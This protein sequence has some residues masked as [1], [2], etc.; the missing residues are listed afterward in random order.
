MDSVLAHGC[1]QLVGSLHYS[2]M[3][4]V[5]GTRPEGGGTSGKE[6]N[7]RGEEVVIAA[8]RVIVASRCEWVRI[9]LQ[10]GMKEDRE[11]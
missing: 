2:D 4:F 3:K 1:L 9:A 7:E 6:E 10:S 5:V 11:R 8:H